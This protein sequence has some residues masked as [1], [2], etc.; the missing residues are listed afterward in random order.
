M[1]IG[2]PLNLPVLPVLSCADLRGSVP[3][4]EHSLLRVGSGVLLDSGASA[5]RAALAAIRVGPGD[6]VLVPAF[7][8]PA[9]LTPVLHAGAEARFYAIE[10]DL[11]ISLA[12]IEGAMG[13]RV[14]AVLVPHLLGR[15]QRLRQIR[16][17][18]DARGAV[19]IE[20]CAH[21]FF[22]SADG[23]PVGTTGHFAV[24]SPRKFLPTIDGGFLTSAERSVAEVARRKRSWRG[25][26]VA[27]FDTLDIASRHGRLWAARPV[28]RAVKA[29]H[30][31]TAGPSVA[32]D[33]DAGANGVEV[34][35]SYEVADAARITRACLRRLITAEAL[36]RRREN[37]A[38]LRAGLQGASAL[39]VLQ[40][41][42]SG[43]DNV[44]YMLPALLHDPARD[45]A[46]LRAAGVP[47]WRWEYS[48]RGICAV[49]DRYAEH[50]IQIPC[51]Q[52]LSQRDLDGMLARLTG[53]AT[54]RARS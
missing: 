8:C 46:R 22:G 17:L 37:F 34:A 29:L 33:V 25:E 54:T 26:L 51:H 18:C 30:A 11:S 19:L 39:T 41:E 16:E 38:Y 21:S 53:P 42:V 5:I 13:P 48:M 4:K 27:C 44:P 32:R 20:D 10:E 3:A 40:I 6:R 49:T 28:V 15:I 31:A 52:S 2:P 24:G 36:R 7:H 35:S 9:M 14:R 23:I 45:Y 50:L 12:A 43:A 47:L 1:S